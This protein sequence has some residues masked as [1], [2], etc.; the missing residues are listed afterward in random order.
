MDGS[1]RWRKLVQRS[2]FSNSCFI[3][4]FPSFSSST[5]RPLFSLSLSS[6]LEPGMFVCCLFSCLSSLSLSHLNHPKFPTNQ[7]FPSPHFSVSLL[8]P[9]KH[10]P[11][12]WSITQCLPGSLAHVREIEESE[13]W[14]Y[15]RPFKEP[16]FLLHQKSFSPTFN[17]QLLCY[18]SIALFHLSIHSMS[19]SSTPSQDLL[20][21]SLNWL[22]QL[23]GHWLKNT[24]NRIGMRTLIWTKQWSE[25]WRVWERWKVFWFHLMKNISCWTQLNAFR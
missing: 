9:P 7:P 16:L 21:L 12:F 20:R 17:C 19:M 6:L 5:F 10:K 23:T 25:I 1:S 22:L 13:E 18:K 14:W 2:S 24:E 11:T 4:S 15:G 3:S 8:L